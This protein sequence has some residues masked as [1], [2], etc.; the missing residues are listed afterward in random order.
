MN[1]KIQ[2]LRSLP[3]FSQLTKTSV[4][5]LTYQFKDINTIKNQ[6]LYKEGDPADLIY[7]IK[8]G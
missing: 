8:N 2:F 3:F 6:V 5:K 7:I 4:S 1:E